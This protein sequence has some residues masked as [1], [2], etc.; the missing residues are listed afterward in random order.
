MRTWLYDRLTTDP[1]LQSDLGG[2]EGITDRVV[3]RRSQGTVPF[4][5]PFLIYGLGNSTNEGL[6]DS[7]A[8]DSDDKDADRQFFE[9]WVHDDSGSYNKIDSIIAKVIR[10]LSGASSP[11]DGIVTVIYLET[12]QEFNNESYGTIFRYIRFQAVKVRGGN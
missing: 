7:T 10:N 5:K 1:D 8:N 11:V 3:P 12:S 2:A 4:L 9:V 6:C